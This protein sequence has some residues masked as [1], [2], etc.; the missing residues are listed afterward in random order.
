M[1]D[2]LFQQSRAVPLGAKRRVLPLRRAGGAAWHTNQEFAPPQLEGTALRPG[3]PRV[4]AVGLQNFV[5]LGSELPQTT[6]THRK[7]R[8]FSTRVETV[9]FPFSASAST[10]P[11]GTQVGYLYVCFFRAP[12]KSYF[13]KLSFVEMISLC[14]ARRAEMNSLCPRAG[15]NSVQKQFMLLNDFLLQPSRAGAARRE[16][17]GTAFTPGGRCHSAHEPGVCSASTGENR[18]QAGR[19]PRARGGLAKLRFAWIGTTSN[20]FRAPEKSFVF[21]SH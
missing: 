6:S 19:A 4:P 9:D 16:K 13:N 14:K 7:N 20:N 10:R 3:R 11:L 21:N 2:F 15:G 5:L 17:E 12:A 1:N 18:P 8:S